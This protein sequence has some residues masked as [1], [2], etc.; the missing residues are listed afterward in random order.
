MRLSD[1]VGCCRI[2]SDAVRCCLRLSDSCLLYTGGCDITIFENEKIQVSFN[3][4]FVKVL[5]N[6]RN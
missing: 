2:L 5:K 6:Q 3:L 1:A 4:T